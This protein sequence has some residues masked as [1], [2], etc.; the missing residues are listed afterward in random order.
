[1]SPIKLKASMGSSVAL[2]RTPNDHTGSLQIKQPVAAAP[3]SGQRVLPVS[4]N[5]SPGIKLK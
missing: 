3:A 1:M 5:L 2:K 4:S